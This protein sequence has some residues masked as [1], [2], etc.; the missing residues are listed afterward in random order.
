MSVT[1]FSVSVEGRITLQLAQVQY[2]DYLTLWIN[3][4]RKTGREEKDFEGVDK[5]ARVIFK[6]TLNKQNVQ[7]CPLLNLA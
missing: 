5:Y 6:C 2:T 3:F 7:V 1:K 4:I